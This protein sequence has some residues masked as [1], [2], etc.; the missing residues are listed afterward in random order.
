MLA[1]GGDPRLPARHRAQARGDRPRAHR[2]RGGARG[3]RRRARARWTLRTRAGERFEA[4]ALVLA[5]GQLSRPRWPSIPGMDE[6][7]GHA[8]HSAE[9]DH[10]YDLAGKRVAVIGTG[11]SAIQFVPAGG[12][13]RGARGRL[14]A[15]RAVHAAAQQRAEYRR[16][17]AA[18]DRSAC[19]GS[20]PRAATGC[21]RSWR[22]SWLGLTR[23][24]PLGWLLRAWSH[25]V[26]AHA[27]DGPGGAPQGVARLPV[28][29]QADPVQLRLPAGAAAPRRGA[30]DRRDQ[31]AS[32]PRGVV[33]RG[34]AR[35]RGGLHRLRHRL[36]LRATSSCRC[37]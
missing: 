5:C 32:P 3:L 16:V 7:E 20:R 1:A 9:W 4:D 33:D 34:R 6:F 27:A 23:V 12:R 22:C 10:D 15:Q 37:G 26:H 14:P 36:P 18:A 31:R 29:L 13:A 17:L 19:R 21:G 11:A 25:R 30:R 35:A 28:R 8:F 24:R 2:H